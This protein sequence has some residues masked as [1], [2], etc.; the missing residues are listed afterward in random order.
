MGL[1]VA[2][3]EGGCSGSLSPGLRYTEEKCGLS[4][5]FIYSPL[6]SPSQ[7]VWLHAAFS[8]FI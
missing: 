5:F 6:L 8:D 3:R 7:V 1:Q 4:G 2:A